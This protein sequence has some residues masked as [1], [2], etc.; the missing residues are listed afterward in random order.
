M[1]IVA[2]TS[3]ILAL[4]DRRESTHVSLRDLYTRT[5][6]H[7]VLP[8]AILPELDYMVATR[9]GSEVH[10]LWLSDLA[11]HVYPVAWNDARDLAS[12]AVLL[13]HNA[14][15]HLGLVD[16]LVMATAER[17]RASAIVTL[18][19]RHFSAVELRCQP[20]LWPRDM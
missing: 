4:I 8:A 9:L 14:H 6:S 13:E 18:D 2:D 15:L 5:R 7:W 1:I 20:L 10:S 12:A 11:S 17:L 3:A 19:V 16:A